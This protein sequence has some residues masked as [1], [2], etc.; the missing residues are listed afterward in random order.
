MMY[1]RHK[2]SCGSEFVPTGYVDMEDVPFA[3]PIDDVVENNDSLMF[4]STINECVPVVKV[5]GIGLPF[6]GGV[7]DF[8]CL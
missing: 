3:T 4:L 1:W 8:M 6:W 5:M 2:R 7:D